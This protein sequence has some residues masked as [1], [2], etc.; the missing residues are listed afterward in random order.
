MEHLIWFIITYLLVFFLYYI[1]I[2][3]SKRKLKKYEDSVEV[4]Y[5]KRA[6]KLD[7]SKINIKKLATSMAFANA[8]IIAF[9]VTAISFVD[10]LILKMLVGFVLLFPL[11]ILTYSFVAN[12]YQPKK[13]KKKNG[14]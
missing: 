1:F 12:R 8:F 11:I 10:N 7:V 14:I 6:Y 4:T 5:L 3:Q 9:V 13:R 2:V